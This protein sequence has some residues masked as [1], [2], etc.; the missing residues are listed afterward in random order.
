MTYCRFS[1]LMHWAMAFLVFSAIMLVELKS[2]LP[3]GELKRDFMI[4]HIEAGML[5]FILVWPRLFWRIGNPS[6]PIL[7][8]LK[9]F[10]RFSATLA[11]QAFYLMMM[12]LPVFGFLAIQSKGGM[13]HFFGLQLPQLIEKNGHA[14]A[15][16]HDHELLGNI[17]IGLIALHLFAVFHHHV[18]RRDNTLKRMSL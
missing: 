5:V 6:P 14:H 17:M 9:P 12:A 7:P 18:F 2:M 13:V 1:R 4:W 16:K 11:H 10:Q 3:R 8:P 15:L